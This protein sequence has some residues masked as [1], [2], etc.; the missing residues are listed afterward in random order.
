MANKKQGFAAV[1]YFDKQ[2]SPDQPIN[3]YAAKWAADDLIDSYGY[4]TLRD[5]IDYYAVHG[6]NKSWNNFCYNAAKVFKNM[7]DERDDKRRRA[8]QKQKAE[9]WLEE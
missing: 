9:S 7:M 8:F 6:M 3:K 4:D 5:M 1:S 2:V